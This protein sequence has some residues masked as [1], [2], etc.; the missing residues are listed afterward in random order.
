[1][2]KLK[3]KILRG[4]KGEL[5]KQHFKAG[6]TPATWRGRTAI[7]KHKLAKRQNR[8]TQRQLAITEQE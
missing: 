1:M 8:R 4:I 6:G 5:R 7:Y 3:N 2:A